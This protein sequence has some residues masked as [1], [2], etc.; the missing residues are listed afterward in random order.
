MQILP[1]KALN[2]KLGLRDTPQAIFTINNEKN[3][4]NKKII[5]S[6]ENVQQFRVNINLLCLMLDSAI[7]LVLCLR[8]TKEIHVYI[9]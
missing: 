2:V 3:F 1:M 4:Q 7:R 9:L 6:Q 5:K 8:Y